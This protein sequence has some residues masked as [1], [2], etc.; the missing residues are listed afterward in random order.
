MKIRLSLKYIGV[1]LILVLTVRLE[2]IGMANPLLNINIEDYIIYDNFL[3]SSSSKEHNTTIRPYCY[4]K[5]LPF[6]DHYERIKVNLSAI[7]DTGYYIKPIST[8]AAIC[9]YSEEDNT[10]LEG[11]SGLKLEKGTNCILFEAGYLSFGKRFVT[12][13]QLKQTF[14]EDETK[15]EFFRGYA[16]LLLYNLSVEAGKDNVNLGPGEYGM[17]LSN[18]TEPYPLVKLQTEDHLKFFGK[19]DFVLLHGWLREKRDDVNNPKLLAIR[20]VWK[21]FNYV[22]IG[23]TRTNMYGGDDRPGYDYS[24]Y[25]ALITGSQED[26]PKEKYNT[27][28]FWGYDISIYLPI[29]RLSPFLKVVKLYFQ[30]AATDMNAPW[31]KSDEYGKSY[32]LLDRAYQTGFFISTKKDVLRFEYAVTD[33]PF[34]TNNPYN[35]EGYSYKG[36]SLGYPYGR[37]MRSFLLKH[38]HYFIDSFSIEYRIGRIQQPLFESEDERREYWELLSPSSDTINKDKERRDYISLLAEYRVNIFIIQIFTR[39]DKT[40]KYDENPLPT[41]FTIIDKDKTFFTTGFSISCWF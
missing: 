9:Y 11:R 6:L 12:Y 26:T 35:V 27:D 29:N 38:R 39:I 4:Y 24:E 36:L 33:Y 20:T 1:L 5:L 41:Q 32:K 25:P 8:I 13:Y 17:L 10:F 34:Y 7:D 16:K 15:N 19:W 31:K 30:E 21:P 23:T 14:N 28:A 40:R 3:S 37:N 2:V 18:N 22:E